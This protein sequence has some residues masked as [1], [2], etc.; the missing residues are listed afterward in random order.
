MKHVQTSWDSGLARTAVNYITSR[1]IHNEM[2]TLCSHK[3]QDTNQ[4]SFSVLWSGHVLQNGGE[5]LPP[6][7]AGAVAVHPGKCWQGSHR[8]TKRPGEAG[9]FWSVNNAIGGASYDV[10]AKLDLVV[11]VT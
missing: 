2:T 7:S 3:T 5:G 6:S 11:P 10:K 4:N 9:V 8:L 1:I